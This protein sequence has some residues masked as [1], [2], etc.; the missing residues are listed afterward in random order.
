[1]LQESK[2]L[3][4]SQMP[5]RI[6]MTSQ[7]ARMTRIVWMDGRELHKNVGD[8]DGPKSRWYGYSV[9]RWDGDYTLELT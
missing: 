6:V 4:F 2:G 8:K 7:Y 1:M 5:D 3:A 9:G